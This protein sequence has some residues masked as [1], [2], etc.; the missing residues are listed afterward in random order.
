MT[1]REDDIEV[2]ATVLKESDNALKSLKIPQ[3]IINKLMPVALTNNVTEE[4]YEKAKRVIENSGLYDDASIFVASVVCARWQTKK[5]Y[6]PESSF[7]S[8]LQYTE[9]G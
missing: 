2:L 7:M 9:R 1:Q 4:D 5:Y 6:G 3:E 8:N